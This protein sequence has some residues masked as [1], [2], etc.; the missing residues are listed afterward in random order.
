EMVLIGVGFLFGGLG[1]LLGLVRPAEFGAI[2]FRVYGALTDADE[3]L[4]ASVPL[5]VFMGATL[6]RA[7]LAQD[8][9]LGVQGLFRRLRGGPLVAVMV[10]GAVLAPTAGAIPASGCALAL[11]ALPVLL[12]EGGH[13]GDARAAA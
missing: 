13:P 5:L 6:Q 8:L 4:Y 12:R 2:F 10:L 3:I 7:G 1:M 11:I 9:L